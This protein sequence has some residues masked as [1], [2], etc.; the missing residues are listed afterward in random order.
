MYNWADANFAYD[1]LPMQLIEFPT[2]P[3]PPELD[4]I[5]NRWEALGSGLTSDGNGAEQFFRAVC[6]ETNVI[7]NIFQ[8]SR[9]AT[10]QLVKSTLAPS[11][12]PSA[13]AASAAAINSPMWTGLVFEPE[14]S[15]AFLD[16]A[17]I[18]IILQ[19][20]R[21]VSFHTTFCVG[22]V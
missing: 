12:R 3:E 15:R 7:E 16:T 5:R 13:A 21:A 8:V 22:L 20:A 19:N 14:N 9:N 4:D 2:T 18:S 6:V 1:W 10:T 11:A 17:E